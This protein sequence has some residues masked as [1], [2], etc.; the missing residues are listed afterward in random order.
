M[1]ESS[2][3]LSTFPNQRVSFESFG[4]LS[5]TLAFDRGHGLRSR[6]VKPWKERDKLQV[7]WTAI[8]ESLKPRPLQYELH[9]YTSSLLWPSQSCSVARNSTQTY[10]RR[11]SR[12]SRQCSSTFGIRLR[13][14]ACMRIHIRRQLCYILVK[15]LF[16][17]LEWLHYNAWISVIFS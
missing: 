6:R 7:Y 9:Q 1:A 14:I 17:E 4:I 2:K 15:L 5:R 12:N 16:C 10:C 13:P 11:R 8:T 3:D